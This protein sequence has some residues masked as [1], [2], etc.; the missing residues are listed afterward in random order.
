[1]R[2]GIHFCPR[3]G[4]ICVVYT[5]MWCVEGLDVQLDGDDVVG[6]PPSVLTRGGGHLY[7]VSLREP[8][9]DL[10]SLA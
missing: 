2:V 3:L 9:V 7:T 10:Y 6:Q 5:V 1:M 4:C 8:S